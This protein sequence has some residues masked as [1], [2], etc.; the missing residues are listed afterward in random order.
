MARKRYH[1]DINDL[2]AQ[3]AIMADHQGYAS[4]TN[5]VDALATAT[6][7]PADHIGGL[8]QRAQSLDMVI[9]DGDRLRVEMLG[10]WP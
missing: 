4:K 10:D 5:V 3:I 6:G 9:V 1:L 8:M 2:L 7:T